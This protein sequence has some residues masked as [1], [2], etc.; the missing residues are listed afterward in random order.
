MTHDSTPPADPNAREV[1]NRTS[2]S[3]ALSIR[4]LP[5]AMREPVE[6]GYL[7]ARAGDTLADRG[8]IEDGE[9]LRRLGALR[10]ALETGTLPGSSSSW[11]SDAAG[12][13]E[14]ARAESTLLRSLPG[15]LE[16]LA[17]L[18]EGDR[19]DV[20]TVVDR[21]VATMEEEIGWFRGASPGSPRALPDAATLRAYTEGIAGCVGTFWTALLARHALAWRGR[22]LLALDAEARRYGRGLQLV[23]VLRD[24]P[25]DL[26]QG[27]L[28]LPADELAARGLEPADLL[29][30]ATLPTLE[31]LLERW[32]SR[33]R[34]GLLAGLAYATRIP[35]RRP[36][37]RLASALPAAIGLRTLD[38]MRASSHRL[39]PERPVRISRSTTRRL[40]V[41]SALLALIPRGPL[42]L[43]TRDRGGN[44]TAAGSY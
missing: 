20:V 29:D 38:A 15:L 44:R 33:C 26:R 8:G 36:G 7:L 42:L 31:A 19:R 24:L 37:L 18:R 34:R 30:A 32:E 23:N 28:F 39:D 35:A 22:E 17:L 43:A 41:G 40:V 13:D 25:R 2:R 9:R 1:L 5:R 27:K 11:A 4:A 21:L 16:R 12:E 6:L 10:G 3:F 14:V